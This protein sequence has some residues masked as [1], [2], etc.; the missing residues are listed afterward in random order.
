MLGL[1]TIQTYT[2]RTSVFLYLA[3]NK[4]LRSNLPDT[5]AKWLDKINQNWEILQDTTAAAGVSYKKQNQKDDFFM[6]RRG[7]ILQCITNNSGKYNSSIYELSGKKVQSYHGIINDGNA[8]I[9]CNLSSLASG[10]YIIRVRTCNRYYIK[11]YTHYQF[12]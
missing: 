10:T 5:V 12:Q 8:I 2:T 4:L 3:G 7:E 9:T 1:N 11:A 6:Q